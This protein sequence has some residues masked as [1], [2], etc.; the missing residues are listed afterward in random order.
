MNIPLGKPYLRKDKILPELEKVIE[1][2][3]ISGGPA[4]KK[5]EDILKTY[6]QDS[7]GEYITVCN[8]TVA[9]EMMLEF[10]GIQ[11]RQDEVIVPSWSWIASGMSIWNVGGTPIF[12]DIDQ[13]GVPT[14]EIIEPLIT[15]QT[16]AIML[17]HQ[18][19]IPCDMDQ[20]NAMASKYRLP[21]I[22]DAACA[23]GSEYKGTKIGNSPNLVTYS[24]QAR[25]VLTTGEGGVIITKDKIAADWFRKK[26]AFGTS[27]VPLERA[28]SNKL[29]G[30]CMTMPATNRRISDIQCAIGLGHIQYV[31]DEIKMR[32]R[33]ALL[34][35]ERIQGLKGIEWCQEIPPYC[36]RYNWQGLHFLVTL[37][38]NRDVLLQY[39]KSNEIGCRW[40]IQGMHLEPAWKR[41]YQ[42]IKLPQT[43]EFHQRGI[44]L[45]FFAEM[46]DLELDYIITHL[47]I[48]LEQAAK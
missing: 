48:G 43:M 8:C 44:W 28:E 32:E 31:D 36:T 5:F 47:K 29:V 39:L 23:F 15:P 16:K 20:I 3:W 14:V 1:S 12:C 33:I 30:E 13:Y 4:I 27:S 6:N 24:F 25:K 9:L 41:K 10:L 26:R 34:Y 18:I 2:R 38:Y 19:G 21:I 42:Q 17:V 37:G 11:D 22:E 46:T 45:P 7:N 35:K 40:D